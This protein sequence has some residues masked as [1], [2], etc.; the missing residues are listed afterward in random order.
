MSIQLR[1][2]HSALRPNAE[3][4]LAVAN[5]YGVRPRVTSVYRSWHEQAELRE[6]YEAGIHPYP[7]ARPGTSAHNYGLAWDSVLP[8]PYASSPEWQRWWEAV[9]EAA[10]FN[11]PSNDDIHAELP[12]WAAYV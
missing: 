8:E 9:R 11:V 6:R 1:G 10:G 5:Y 2:L 7:V 12:N 4:A 3:W